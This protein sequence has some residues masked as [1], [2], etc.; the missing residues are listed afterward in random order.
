MIYRVFFMFVMAGMLWLPASVL[1]QQE[2]EVPAG[3]TIH[4][5][6]R[7]ENLFRIALSYGLTTDELAAIN[8]ITNTNNIYV[9]QRLLVPAPQ[10]V[11][12]EPQVHIVQPGETLADI[13]TLYGKTLEELVAINEIGNINRI[14]SGQQLY[15]T[16]PDAET[17]QPEQPAPAAPLPESEMG[18]TSILHT[19]QSGETLFRIGLRYGRTVNELAAANN[20]T[21]PTLIYTGQQLL[22]PDVQVPQL[23]VELPAPITA[24]NVQPLIPMEGGTASVRITTSTPATLSAEFLGRSLHVITQEGGTEHIMLIGVPMFTEPDIYPFTLEL[25]AAGGAQ[26][27][28]GFNLQIVSGGYGQQIINLPAELLGLLEPGTE[29]YELNLMRTLTANVTAERYFSG[30]LGLPAAAPMNAAFGIRRSYNG[31]AF[32]RYHNGVDFAGAPGTPILA[33]APGRVVLVDFLN[34]RGI[35]TVIDHGWGV[36]T[37]YAHQMASNVQVGDFVQTSQ[38]IGTVGSSGRV[39]GAHLHWEVWVNGIAVDPLQWVQQSLP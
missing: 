31:S 22:I 6:Q 5:V 39:T 27:S 24:L 8:G 30:P 1:A 37:V 10:S 19:V 2:P 17:Q 28:F 18:T 25:A 29:E 21:D 11:H 35:T 16:Q 36:Y 3:L 23:A 20:L 38:P 15:I 12:H 33:A 14:Y 4:V 34:I 7:G 13:A 26:I 32:D 9:G